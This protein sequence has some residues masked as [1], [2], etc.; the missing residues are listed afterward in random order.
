MGAAQ[1]RALGLNISALWTCSCPISSSP[2]CSTSKTRRPHAARRRAQFNQAPGSSPGRAGNSPE[3]DSQAEPPPLR[4]TKVSSPLPA[5]L[6]GLGCPCPGFAHPAWHQISRRRSL[7]ERG[8][9]REPGPSS[10]PRLPAGTGPLRPARRGLARTGC[11]EAG[12]RQ[13]CM[14]QFGFSAQRLVPGRAQ[15]RATA[16]GTSP[17]GKSVSEAAKFLQLA[18]GKQS[19][20]SFLEIQGGYRGKEPPSPRSLGWDNWDEPVT[21]GQPRAEPGPSEGFGPTCV[22]RTVFDLELGLVLVGNVL[23]SG[24]EHLPLCSEERNQHSEA[25]GPAAPSASRRWV[26]YR[27]HAATSPAAEGI[28]PRHAATPS[29]AASQ[30]QPHP[31]AGKLPTRGGGGRS[32]ATLARGRGW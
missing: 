24:Q 8:G 4:S 22:E 16:A 32:Q 29:P 31:A 11:R 13:G 7:G 28:L 25:T 20:S 5:G 6:K 17:P 10:C 19:S 2:R 15:Q 30:D 9:T 14:I 27:G 18:N 26:R 1:G 3:L 21:S 23:P 12:Q